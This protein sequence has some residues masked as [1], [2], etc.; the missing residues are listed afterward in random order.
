[1]KLRVLTTAFFFPSLSVRT[2]DPS[3]LQTLAA[4]EN[5]AS[6]CELCLRLVCS[7]YEFVH[8]MCYR[9]DYNPPQEHIT[10]TYCNHPETKPRTDY[11]KDCGSA[12]CIHSN[13]HSQY[14]QRG[15]QP[16]CAN[17]AKGPACAAHHTCTVVATPKPP[18]THTTRQS[19]C[20]SC[21]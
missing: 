7:A 1:M 14:C 15:K 8:R 4:I 6:E 17:C 11:Q 20:P 19:L 12:T 21:R 16:N 3:P 2:F 18:D 10:Y 13:H 5:P 9:P